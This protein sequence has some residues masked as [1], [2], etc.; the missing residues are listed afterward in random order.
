MKV[1][2]PPKSKTGGGELSSTERIL[3][4]IQQVNARIAADKEEREQR[5][6]EYEQRLDERFDAFDERITA[7]ERGGARAPVSVPGVE[8]N[9][10]SFARAILAMSSGDWGDAGYEQEVFRE[11][12][13]QQR[14]GPLAA[15]SG[16][17]SHVVPEEVMSELIPLLRSELIFT[18]MGVTELNLQGR[19]YNVDIPKQSA[20]AT[21]YWVGENSAITEDSTFDTTNITLSPKKCGALL[22]YSRTLLRTGTVVQVE[23]MVRRDLAAVLA[24]KIQDAWLNSS[25]GSGSDPNG[26]IPQLTASVTFGADET[27]NDTRENLVKMVEELDATNVP[28]DNSW[29]WASHPRALYKIARLNY[30]NTKTPILTGPAGGDWSAEI[31]RMLLGFPFFTTTDFDVDTAPTGND[32]VDVLIGCWSECYWAIWGDMELAASEQAGTAFAEDQVWVRAI[33]ETDF[34]YKHLGSFILGENLEIST[35]T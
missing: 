23:Q 29:A 24:R 33:Q 19:G 26:L 15:G 9:K 5:R 13:K 11:T 18:Q 16:A 10:F 34:G 35:T 20:A 21:G 12:S 2:T 1:A 7:V 6:S 4:Q 31:K 17:G 3:D 22:P 28:R 14:A 30:D 8:P 32:Q 25:V 27:A